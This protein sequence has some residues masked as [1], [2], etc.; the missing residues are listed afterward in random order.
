[1]F[2]KIPLNSKDL[3]NIHKTQKSN[4]LYI[5]RDTE[6]YYL[7]LATI[8]CHS[9]HVRALIGEIQVIFV[10]LPVYFFTLSFLFMKFSLTY[11]K[12][13]LRSCKYQT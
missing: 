10:G 3:L 12:L 13:K 8:W 5:Y 4:D 1:M 6:R 11:M 7:V 9:H 2:R